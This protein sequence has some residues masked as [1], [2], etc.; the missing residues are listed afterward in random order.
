[1]S[2][3]AEDGRRNLWFGTVDRM[4]WVPTP[5]RG[6]D[7]SGVGWQAGGELLS[8]GAYQ[9]NS[10]N[11]AKNFS[12]E[13]P[14]SSS[15]TAA[16]LMK[17]YADGT[18]GRGLIYFLDPLTYNTNV[19]PALWADPSMAIMSESNTVVPG[20]TPTSVPTTGNPD[21]RLPVRSAFYNLSSVGA[22]L[23]SMLD[24]SNSV[25]IPIPNGFTLFM[26]AFYNF[27]GSAGVYYSS[28]F[29][30]GATSGATIIPPL[31]SSG[32]DLFNAFIAAPPGQVGIR[33]WVGKTA[34]GSSSITL[35]AIHAR[36][37]PQG[38]P[39]QSLQVGEP[40]W[41]GGQGHSGCRFVGYPTYINNTG[42]DGGQ[43]SYAASFRE[44]GSWVM[45]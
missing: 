16:Q 29:Q 13:W 14:Q 40:F 34:S 23:P 9:F 41:V 18:Y 44:V 32:E 39:Y 42:T 20:V 17:S 7:V 33:L 10:F 38:V 24:D 6:A 27:V 22:T 45:G 1:M 36:L 4:E 37:F 21:L 31:D 3:L 2:V 25:F 43:V 12:F 26:G 19:L 30:G 8:G 28:V 5:N 11:S 35:S 15:R